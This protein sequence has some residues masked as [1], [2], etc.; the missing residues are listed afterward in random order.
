MA[1][2]GDFLNDLEANTIP[3]WK[4]FLGT[5]SR[6]EDARALAHFWIELFEITKGV[7]SQMPIAFSAVIKLDSDALKL[8]EVLSAPTS[9][10]GKAIKF[11]GSAANAI[12]LLVT[13]VECVQH[14]RRGDPGPFAAELYKFG[15]GKAVP[16]ASMIDGLGQLL[17]GVV[18]AQT[19]Q[20]SM[21]FKILRAVDPIGMGGVAIDSL[22]SIVS[23]GFEMAAHGKVDVD[24]LTSR[25][26]PLVGRMKQGP[27]RL[28]AELGENSGDALYELSQTDI[29]WQAILRYSY[30]EL[31]EW[32]QSAGPSTRL[33]GI[34]RGTI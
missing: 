2:F 29:D 3:G 30:M 5:I 1:L 34:R 24:V 11:A 16:W 12:G 14:A 19:R 20:N 7:R 6:L 17:D 9:K 15:M 33:G 31:E 21:L 18:P 28:F 8:F 23:S 27:A 22:V 10:L 25:L 13:V 26:G 32:F 4:N